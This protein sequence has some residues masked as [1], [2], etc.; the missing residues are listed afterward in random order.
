MQRY[1]FSLIMLL[2]G[3]AN[4]QADTALEGHVF[5]IEPFYGP[6]VTV[7]DDGWDEH[8]TTGSTFGAIGS[9]QA[10][11]GFY[12]QMGFSSEY[13]DEG[14]IDG[15]TYDIDESFSARTLGVGYR[16]A[17]NREQ[18]RFWGIGYG[19]TKQDDKNL[20][21]PYSKPVHSFR[22]FWEKENSRRYGNISISHNTNSHMRSF[23]VSGRHVWL[24]QSGFGGGFFW[25]VG[26]GKFDGGYVEDY[27]FGA[28][29]GGLLLM[30]RI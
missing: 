7:L 16:F 4:V 10:S 29:S 24:G 1:F 22:V 3:V 9:F 5:R 6:V 17:V 20:G 21:G 12:A 26:S 28:A 25:S 23:S 30:F 8:S 2:T 18:G 27:G 19:N 11:Q 13:V 15:E 14:K